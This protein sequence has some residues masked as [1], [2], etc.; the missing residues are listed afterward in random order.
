[1]KI[2]FEGPSLELMLYTSKNPAEIISEHS[3]HVGPTIIPPK[4]LFS[5]WK[6]RNDHFNL[7]TYY[8]G[9][10]VTTQYCSQVVED[11]LMME[12]L[13]YSLQCLLVRQAM[14]DWKNR[15]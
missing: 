1:M 12:A 5:C 4:W 2:S 8:D 15:L 10:P 3:L 11:I 13:R 14:G 9:T 6:W 7:K